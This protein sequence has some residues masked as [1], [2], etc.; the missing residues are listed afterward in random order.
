[1]EEVFNYDFGGIGFGYVCVCPRNML[2]VVI[3]V[4]FCPLNILQIGTMSSTLSVAAICYTNVYKTI[5]M[6]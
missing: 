1:M 5:L 2:H 3:A 6:M 4:C